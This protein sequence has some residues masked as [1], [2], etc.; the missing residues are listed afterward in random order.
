MPKMLLLP[1]IMKSQ[2]TRLGLQLTMLGDLIRTKRSGLLMKS[3]LLI[4]LPLLK[5]LVL[6]LMMMPTRELQLL[7]ML[8]SN[9]HISKQK[10]IK[11]AKQLMKQSKNARFLLMMSQLLKRL[12]PTLI[13]CMQLLELVLTKPPLNHGSEPGTPTPSRMLKL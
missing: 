13:T 1:T 9:L 5:L 6:N 4:L 12:L 8:L 11:L 7:K 3:L 2:S 10:P